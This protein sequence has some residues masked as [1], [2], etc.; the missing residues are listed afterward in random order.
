VK[1]LNSQV[2]CKENQVGLL[3]ICLYQTF[4]DSFKRFWFYQYMENAMIIVL[5]MNMSY[6]L[7]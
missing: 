5:N 7:P 4:V 3:A 2:S 6:K 1:K